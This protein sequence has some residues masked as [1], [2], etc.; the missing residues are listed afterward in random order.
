MNSIGFLAKA[1]RRKEEFVSGFAPLRLCEEH[2][3]VSFLET[4][5][6][7]VRKSI[8]QS[9]FTPASDTVRSPAT[10]VTNEPT[11]P[12][13]HVSQVIKPALTVIAVSSQRLRYRCA[14]SATQMSAATIL[15]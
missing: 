7:K 13:R 3:L 15:R 14:L 9:S 5:L 4:L 11:T 2:L 6:H 8:T 1:Q 12:Q 10:H